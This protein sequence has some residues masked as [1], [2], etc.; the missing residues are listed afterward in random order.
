MEPLKLYKSTLETYTVYIIYIVAR[1]SWKAWNSKLRL[2][3]IS[4]INIKIVELSLFI[5]EKNTKQFNVVTQ[6][7]MP[8]FTDNS[9]PA[10]VLLS[11]T[12]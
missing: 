10:E 11:I 12:D 3:F 5:Y 8:E 1:G 7:F 6:S 2:Y 4:S 9:R